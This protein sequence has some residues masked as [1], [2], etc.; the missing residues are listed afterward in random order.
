[1]IT[2]TAKK[3]ALGVL[4]GLFLSMNLQAATTGTIALSGSEPAILEI[5]VTS[6]QAASNLPLNT[7][8]TDLKVGTVVERSNKKAGYTITLGSANAL[9]AATVTASLRSTETVDFLPY[10]IKY[11]GNPVAFQSSGG[12]AVVTTVTSKTS[13]AGSVKNLTITFDGASAFLDQA[14]YSDVLTFTI[15]AK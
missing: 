1:M 11:G 14:V 8:V 12:A 7:S 3:K 4:I 2:I 9:A 13:A 5:T 10:S 15:I 6:E